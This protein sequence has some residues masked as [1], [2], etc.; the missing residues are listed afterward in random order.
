MSG[1]TLGFLRV[2]AHGV[3]TPTLAV[4]DHNLFDL[5]VLGHG[6]IATGAREHLVD[7]LAAATDR[8]AH[9]VLAASALEGAQTLG[10]DHAGIPDEHAAAEL[11]ALQVF[12]DLRHRGHID[13]VARE[14]P[15]PHRKAIARD[16]KCN[17]D[18][19]GF[20]AAI[21]GVPALPQSLIGLGTG[22]LTAA[23]LIVLTDA[24][25]GL[26]DLE[27]Q[28]GGVVEDDLHVQVQTI[29][30]AEVDRLLDPLLVGLEKIHPSVWVLE[31][32]SLRPLDR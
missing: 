16:R 21:L 27:V 23:H 14:D 25:I 19:R 22:K 5:Q 1:L 9:D 2:V 8:H 20:D 30:H 7:P 11:S 15:V 31:L 26:I 6:L 28:R 12:L 10:A 13:R 4:S 24:A 32:Q 3:T 17:D 29:R 18:L